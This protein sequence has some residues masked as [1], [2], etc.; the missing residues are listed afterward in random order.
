MDDSHEDDEEEHDDGVDDD[1]GD[2][3]D[4]DDDSDDDDD[5]DEA[6]DRDCIHTGSVVFQW[7]LA[8]FSDKDTGNIG[9]DYPV[10]SPTK[11]LWMCYILSPLPWRLLLYVTK[12]ILFHA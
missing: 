8:L 6:G 5:D 9:V 11:R 2:D 7:L 3:D 10:C 4:S 1:D 12:Y